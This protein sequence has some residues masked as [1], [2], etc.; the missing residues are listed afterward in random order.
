MPKPWDNVRNAGRWALTIFS[1]AIFSGCS[2]TGNLG[3]VRSSPQQSDRDSENQPGLQSNGHSFYYWYAKWADSTERGDEQARIAGEAAISAMKQSG[4]NALPLLLTR[5]KADDLSS[6][7]PYVA[8]NSV[9]MILGPIAAPAIPELERMIQ[10]PKRV[11]PSLADCLAVI[12]D[13]A[14][15][16]FIRLLENP[17]KRVRYSVTYQLGAELQFGKAFTRGTNLLALIQPLIQRTED[18][19]P[20]TAIAAIQALAAVKMEVALTRAAFERAA[21]APNKEVR[22]AAITALKAIT[23]Q[24]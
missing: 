9:F 21:A 19:E 3:Q 17:H 15:P 11:S 10:D 22:A 13:P 7:E 16:A 14:I 4:T 24:D 6:I 12:G 20:Y 18:V 8:P 2:S 5:L 23:T 1:L